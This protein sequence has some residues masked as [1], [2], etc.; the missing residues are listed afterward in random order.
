MNGVG[1]V[2]K[3]LEYPSNFTTNMA[4]FTPLQAMDVTE[5]IQFSVAW[6]KF[7]HWMPYLFHLGKS[8]IG[9]YEA[10]LS[11]TYMMCVCV[12]LCV[13]VSNQCLEMVTR[14]ISHDEP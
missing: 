11:V 10:E 14:K 1:G 9:S 8:R 4:F 6:Q 7:R 5:I 13:C 2:R 12:R 3:L